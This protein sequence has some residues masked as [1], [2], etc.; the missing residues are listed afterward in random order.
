MKPGGI[1]LTY[2]P[3]E[4]TRRT[5]LSVFPHAL[6]FHAPGYASFIVASN[7]PIEFDRESALGVLHSE[8]LRRY[9]SDSGEAGVTRMLED[10][11]M[12]TSV[13]VIGP[14]NRE[15]YLDGNVNRDLYPRDEYDKSYD[16]TYQ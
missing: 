13:T 11:L 10:Y 5:V 9:L 4:R 1:L 8:K 15:E 12:Q 6:D 3:T 16:G 14:A 7:E 2:V